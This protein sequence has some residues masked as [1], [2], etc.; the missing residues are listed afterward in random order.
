MKVAVFGTGAV[1]AYY[2]GRLA[3]SGVAVSFVARGLHLQAIR[4]QGL[5]VDSIKGDFT[6]TPAQVTDDCAEIGEVD[7]VLVCVKGWQVAEALHQIEHLVGEHTVL[8]P[9][10]NGVDAV[11]LLSEKF[12]SDKV[13]NGL[14][15]IFA[16]LTAPGYV[17]HVGSQPWL[18]FGEQDN[19]LTLR[20]RNVLALL[21][22]TDGFS[23]KLVENINTAVWRKFIFI[24]ST[25]GVGSI[26][27]ASFGEVR[28]N[29]QTEKLLSEVVDEIITVAK[30]YN[31]ELPEDVKALIWQQ[32]CRSSDSSDTS[33][34]R[35]VL[36]GR[37][38]EL[39]S[40]TGA[41]IRLGKQVGVATPLNDMIYAA[42]LPQEKR[43][44]A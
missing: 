39:D 16:K 13:L 42:L 31:V 32:I 3:Q 28:A 38:S 4:E 6:V 35:D 14:C 43:A 15:G 11:G 1:G 40:Q 44:R 2:G 26:C 8:L 19:Q 34:Q 29:P 9:L 21:Q 37:P 27:R 7:L 25:S 17:S 5:K 24:A 23:S 36:M 41:V 22:S 20:A 18:Q 12:G 33:M 10:L 30:A